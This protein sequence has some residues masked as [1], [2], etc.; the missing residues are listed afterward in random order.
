VQDQ[1]ERQL[2]AQPA[3][4]GGE[5]G[6]GGRRG[7][8]EHLVDHPRALSD[9]RMERM[10][11]G[12]HQMEIRHR[13]QLLAPFR[14]P[15]LLGSGLALWAVAVAARVI[16]VARHPAAVTGLDVAAEDGRAT[17][18]D[19][20]P[21]LGLGRRQEVLGE[22]RR[23]VPAEDLGQGHWRWLNER[24]EQFQGRGVAGQL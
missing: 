2:P 1:R 15:V 19:R 14:Q 7:A 6:E 21:D 16:D 11:Q 20:P 4:V 18:D 8:E 5:F 22:V 17:G 23:P 10:R 13:Q 3:R 24:V 12:E 9:Q